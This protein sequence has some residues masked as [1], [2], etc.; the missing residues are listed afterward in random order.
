MELLHSKLLQEV[1][2]LFLWA[3]T[4]RLTRHLYTTSWDE[5]AYQTLS[6]LRCIPR[7]YSP[8]SDEYFT[9]FAEEF[10]FAPLHRA[11]HDNIQASNP[12]WLPYYLTLNYL[13]YTVYEPHARYSQLST[14]DTVKDMIIWISPFLKE[15]TMIEHTSQR[16][17]NG[18]ISDW[19]EKEFLLGL[20]SRLPQNLRDALSPWSQYAQGRMLESAIRSRASTKALSEQYFINLQLSEGHTTRCG[21]ALLRDIS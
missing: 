11:W 5:E 1:R 19:K 21:M 2:N 20:F 10:R 17:N 9:R 14:Q 16:I 15:I 18:A 6:D 3:R 13:Y 7:G 12:R 8:S 4:H